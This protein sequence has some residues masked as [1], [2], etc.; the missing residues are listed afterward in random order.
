MG[1]NGP[2][3]IDHGVVMEWHRTFNWLICFQD[4]QRDDVDTPT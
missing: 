1:L 2:A 4:A 3:D